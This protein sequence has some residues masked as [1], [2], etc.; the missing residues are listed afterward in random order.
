MPG[1]K[2][3]QV[4]MGGRGHTGRNFGI[5]SGESKLFL[6]NLDT[7]VGEIRLLL[8]YTIQQ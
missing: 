3:I 4:T 7:G 2:I 8:E 6:D 5:I 1:W